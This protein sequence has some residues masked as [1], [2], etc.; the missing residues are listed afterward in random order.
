[1]IFAMIHH[2]HVF[3]VD[4][5]DFPTKSS[6]LVFNFWEAKNLPFRI[7]QFQGLSG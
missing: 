7:L 4:L 5:W 2:I 3:L 6:P 1:M